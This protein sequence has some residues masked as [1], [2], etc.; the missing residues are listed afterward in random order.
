MCL[1]HDGQPTPITILVSPRP[2]LLNLS[3]P[4][5]PHPCSK[6]GPG[7]VL[8]ECLWA[9]WLAGWVSGWMDGWWLDG[10]WLDGWTD[11]RIDQCVSEQLGRWKIV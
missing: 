7:E 6:P 2:Y 3:L 11:Q 8:S 9:G 4:P 5:L 1:L 10:W